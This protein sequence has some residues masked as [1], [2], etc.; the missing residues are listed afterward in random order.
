M[1]KLLASETVKNGNYTEKNT[2]VKCR[3]IITSHIVLQT[4]VF[5]CVSMVNYKITN[6]VLEKIISNK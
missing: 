4:C 3:Y 6:T 1:T 2:G 5:Y